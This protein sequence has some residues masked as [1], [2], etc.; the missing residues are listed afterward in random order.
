MPNSLASHP[1]CEIANNVA[2]YCEIPGDQLPYLIARQGLQVEDLRR[3]DGLEGA[4]RLHECA[5]GVT[6]PVVVRAHEQDRSSRNLSGDKV[7]EFERG[8]VCP[9]EVLEDA[10]KWGAVGVSLQEFG[11]VPHETRTEFVGFTRGGPLECL[12]GVAEGWEEVAKFGLSPSSK[13][14][15]C[16]GLHGIE[17]RNP[18]VREH[19]IGHA[20]PDGIGAASDDRPGSTLCTVCEFGHESGLSDTALAPHEDDAR[21]RLASLHESLEAREFRSAADQ[22]K[23]GREIS[24]V[25][26]R[27]PSADGFR[28]LVLLRSETAQRTRTL[29]WWPRD[30]ERSGGTRRVPNRAM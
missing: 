23:K 9:L 14:R 19:R 11:E 29:S 5:T 20:G 12:G 25:A 3:S 18:R 28:H 21:T 6:L 1:I 8:L 10:E 2:I 7:Q 17:S 26:I 16:A 30:V 24:P 13:H 22:G 27:M 15:E 4:F